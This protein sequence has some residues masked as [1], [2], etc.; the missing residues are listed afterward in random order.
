MKLYKKSL[1]CFLGFH[2]Y[3]NEEGYSHLSINAYRIYYCKRNINH[4]TIVLSPTES[5]PKITKIEKMIQ[6]ILR[7]GK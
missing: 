5:I 4:K 1:L 2:L 7:I 3:D 6:K